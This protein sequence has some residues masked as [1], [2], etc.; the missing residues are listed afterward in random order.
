[1]T[2]SKEIFFKNIYIILSIFPNLKIIFL[3]LKKI[4]TLT[5][6]EKNNLNYFIFILQILSSSATLNF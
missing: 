6:K 4:S 1:M 5:I 3:W 2:V